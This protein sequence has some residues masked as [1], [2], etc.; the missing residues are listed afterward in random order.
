MLELA[1]ESLAQKTT[2]TKLYLLAFL[3]IGTVQPRLDSAPNYQ[4]F[5]LSSQLF[6]SGQ[7]DILTGGQGDKG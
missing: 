2:P 5:V 7:L 6:P 4:D 3:G 1:G